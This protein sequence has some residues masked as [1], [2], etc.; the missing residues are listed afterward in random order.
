MNGE[1]SF[2][3]HSI[4]LPA[5][6]GDDFPLPSSFWERVSFHLRFCS[7]RVPIV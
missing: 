3:L 5:E 1:T 6:V 4:S 2:T 7:E